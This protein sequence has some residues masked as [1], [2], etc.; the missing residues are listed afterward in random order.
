MPTYPTRRRHK[1][2][3]SGP[4]IRVPVVVMAHEVDGEFTENMFMGYSP[5]KG[6]VWAAVKPS[7]SKYWAVVHADSGYILRR[8]IR[9]ADQAK[10]V[11]ERMDKYWRN[12]SWE[13]VLEH[14]TGIQSDLYYKREEFRFRN[15][16]APNLY[17]SV[18]LGSWVEPDQETVWSKEAKELVDPGTL[19]LIA[20]EWEIM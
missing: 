20:G 17:W 8:A 12:C 14:N 13:T 9:T 7:W 11:V 5:Y 15:I 1:P 18:E 2:R 6:C 10:V 16:T 19:P 4:M 3:K